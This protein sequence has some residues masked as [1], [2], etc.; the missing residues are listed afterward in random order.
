MITE[1]NIL[2]H[3]LIGLQCEVKESRNKSQVGMK[4]KVVDETRNTL[5]IETEKGEKQIEKKNAR[6]IFKIQ[7]EKKVAVDGELLIGRPEAR[8]KC[9]HPKKRV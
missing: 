9:A 7:G 3:E 1:K 8:T 5:T 6:F 2:K 4:G